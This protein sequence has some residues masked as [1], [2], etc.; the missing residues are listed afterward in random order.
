MSSEQ[1]ARVHQDPFTLRDLAYIVERA[2]LIFSIALLI[3]LLW[4]VFVD[5]TFVHL[6][7]VLYTVLW[8]AFLIEFV[9]KLLTAKNKWNYLKRDFLVIFI[10]LF[11]FLRPLRLFPF[12]RFGILVF[13]EQANHRFPAFRR[14]RIFE[15]L[16]F[17]IVLVILSAD[18]FLMFEKTPDSLFKN[19][20]DALWFSVVTVATVGYGDVYPKTPNGRALAVLL[21]IFGVS[22]FGIVTASISSYLVEM[23]IKDER[24]N[25]EKKI[26]DLQREEKEMEN[27]LELMYEKESYIQNKL[28]EISKRFENA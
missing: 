6:T 18:L 8:V 21:I 1:H 4:N 10:I 15:I 23:D 11:P 26:E 13:A 28:D 3:L 9:L 20:A 14:Y 25:E 27:K 22:I 17:S 16:L 19:F 12:S 24:K 2:L 7:D 5:S